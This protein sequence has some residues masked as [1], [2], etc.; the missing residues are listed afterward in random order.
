MKCDV[1][2]VNNCRVQLSCLVSSEGAFCHSNLFH[3]LW[4]R[5][6]I[7]AT[8]LQYHIEHLCH[9]GGTTTCAT[10]LTHCGHICCRNRGA[11]LW[12]HLMSRQ[13]RHT[14]DTFV[15]ET[16]APHCGP[17]CC[18]DR[19]AT[20]WTH[21]MSRQRRHTVDTFDVQT[22]AAHCGHI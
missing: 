1:F 17:I 12:T 13:R 2:K 14:V 7:F 16:E 18:R 3:M 15:V 22:E 11:T 4:S 6:G 10:L 8:L 20:L 21:L 19:G 9:N 5:I